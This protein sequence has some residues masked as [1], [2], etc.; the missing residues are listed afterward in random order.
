MGATHPENDKKLDKEKSDLLEIL[1]QTAVQF[2]KWVIYSLLCHRE[3]K[4]DKD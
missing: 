4:E 3:G 2:Q 1:E